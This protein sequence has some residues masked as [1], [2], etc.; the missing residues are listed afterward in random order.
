[1]PIDIFTTYMYYYIILPTNT[2]CNLQPPKAGIL[3][4]AK[5]TRKQ[6]NIKH[7]T[8][9]LVLLLLLQHGQK[10]GYQLSQELEEFSD[11]SY[12]LKEATMYPTLYRL[13]QNGYL[14]CN[15]VKVGERRMRVYYEI[16]PEGR[17]HLAEL[18][19]EYSI[20]IGA[21]DKIMKHTD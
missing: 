18:R 11:G 20:I 5:K 1:M 13:T 2:I 16:T 3:Y 7:G 17:E 8:I 10:Y 6:N 14:N 19:K 12:E 15:Q 4:M 21:I 9:E